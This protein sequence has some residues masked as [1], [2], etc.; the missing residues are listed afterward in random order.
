MSTRSQRYE[1]LVIVSNEELAR[2]EQENNRN[3][4]RDMASLE[5]QHDGLGGNQDLPIDN[6]QA[7]NNAAG[8]NPPLNPLMF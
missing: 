3:I 4:R 5:N 1:N 6:E 2:I 7:A 8:G